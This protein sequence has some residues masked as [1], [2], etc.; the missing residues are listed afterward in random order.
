MKRRKTIA[1]LL[2]A[3]ML[4]GLLAGCQGGGGTDTPQPGGANEPATQTVDYANDPNWFGTDDGKKVTLNFY[5]GIQPEYGYQQMVDNFNAEYA[6]KGVEVVFNKYSNDS[7]GNLQLDTQ[8]LTGTFVDVF[9]GYGS[10]DRLY[11]RGEAGMLYDYSGYLKSI[12][13]DVAK[14]LGANTAADYIRE[15]GTVWG[16]PTKFDNKGGIMINT[17]AFEEAG[18]PLPLHGWTYDEFRD[19]CRKLHEKTGKYAVCWGLGFD[20]ASKLGYVS[21]VLTPNCYFT[22]ETVSKTNLDNPVWI[23]GLQLIKDSFDEGWALPLEEDLAGKKDTVKTEY[24]T[25]NCAIFALYSQLRLA[26]DTTSY[27]HDFVTAMVPF[28]VPSE[29]YAAYKDQ[30]NQSY[31][32]D[33]ISISSSCENKKAACEFTRWYIM[34]GMNP[35]IL[36]ARYPMWSGNNT[37]DILDIVSANAHGAVNLDSLTILFQQVD[38]FSAGATGYVSG[39][40]D[41]I[42][43]IVWE[44][45]QGFLSGETPTAEQAMKNA[46]QRADEAIKVAGSLIAD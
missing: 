36:A 22:D 20:Y 38:R 40:D 26:M 42:K 11:S 24:L 23:E 37:Q 29:E 33:Y 6:D 21:S 10:R 16:L 4:A 41:E 9:I 14:E 12:G 31:S 13:F 18:V 25:G 45:W 39:H 43:E 1:L 2:T 30:A 17:D 8:L 44:E 7:D 35:I 27:P 34:G 5:C 19:A 3:V 32:G 46:K 28:P 15:D